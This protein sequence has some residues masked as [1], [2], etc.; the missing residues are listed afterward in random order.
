MAELD[1]KFDH[2]VQFS[3]NDTSIR[4]NIN[5]MNKT[6]RSLGVDKNCSHFMGE[7]RHPQITP[8]DKN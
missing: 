2:A 8:D 4:E 6:S 7:T 1:E 3:E 5:I